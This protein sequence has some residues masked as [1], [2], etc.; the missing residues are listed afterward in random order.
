MSKPLIIADSREQKPY[1]YPETET[2]A[3]T[4]VEK[5]AAGDYSIEGLEHKIFIDRKLSTAEL[6]KNIVEDRFHRLLEKAKE[7]EYKFLLLEFDLEDIY[8]FPINSQMP[9]WQQKRCRISPAFLES[10][11]TRIMTDYGIHVVFTGN[12]E[13]GEKICYSILKNILKKESIKKN[14]SE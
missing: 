4:K 12:H 1:D 8:T 2:F 11:I 9:R 5:V 14:V 3:G 10:F 6:A 7:Y 13:Q